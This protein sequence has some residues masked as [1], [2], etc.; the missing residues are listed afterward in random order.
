MLLKVIIRPLVSNYVA[1]ELRFKPTGWGRPSF[2]TALSS[3]WTASI[4]FLSKKI[5][6][7]NESSQ[8]LQEVNAKIA[9]VTLN[10]SLYIFLEETLWLEGMFGM[11][12]TDIA[13]PNKSITLN[14]IFPVFG[15]L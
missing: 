12:Y 4:A 11:A 3:D 9:T 7:L 10:H 1:K 6:L 8:E 14:K 5:S 2:F 15:W 13:V